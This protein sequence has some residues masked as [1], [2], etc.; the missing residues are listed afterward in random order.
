MKFE[1]VVL[2]AHIG[3]HIRDEISK[4]KNS[5]I[6]LVEPVPHNVDAIKEN[7]KEFKNIIIEPVAISNINE[8][9]DFY[10]VKGNSINKLKKHWASGIGSFDKNHLISH[11]SKRFL[12]EDNDI[13]KVVIETLRFKDLVKKHS[14]TEIEK[15]I[16]D[17]EGFEYEILSDIDLGEIKINSIMFEYKHFDGYLK[18]GDKLQEIIQKFEK[19]NYKISKIDKENIL[20]IKH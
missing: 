10:F 15:I 16:I 1:L 5:P 18:S 11:R 13:D 7:L 2:G 20:A 3:V 6:L 14:I 12:I 4:I 19:N 8:K 17:V 9:K